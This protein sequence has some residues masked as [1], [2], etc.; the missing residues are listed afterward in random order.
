MAHS[1]Y[2][3]LQQRAQTLVLLGVTDRVSS[4]STVSPLS[5][6]RAVFMAAPISAA[7]GEAIRARAQALL[8]PTGLGTFLPEV[9]IS[10]AT[11]HRK[12]DAEGTGPGM[13]YAI[14][15]LEA[16]DEAR[17][18]AFSGLM[19]PP[20]ENWKIFFSKV[21]RFDHK[22]INRACGPRSHRS[23]ACAPGERAGRA[24]EGAD[25]LAHRGPP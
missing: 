9:V 8:P 13:Q 6:D 18:P 1:A 10:Y 5:R 16:L 4:C 23:R 15:L 17:I 22:P 14:A 3:V 24:G 12:V 19:V 7:E 20:A 11:G 21:R 2:F 25:H